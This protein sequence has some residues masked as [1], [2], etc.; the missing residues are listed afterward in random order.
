MLGINSV[1]REAPPRCA[2]SIVNTIGPNATA[3]CNPIR[4]LRERA[5]TAK[6]PVGFIICRQV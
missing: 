4:L 6:S 1:L 2:S 5:L 3:T